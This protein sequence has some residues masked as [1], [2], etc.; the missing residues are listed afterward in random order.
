MKL[1]K[2]D[3]A[4]MSHYTVAEAICKISVSSHLDLELCV[5]VIYFV[6][7]MCYILF[8][9]CYFFLFFFFYTLVYFDD[10]D[11]FFAANCVSA[12]RGKRVRRL[13]GV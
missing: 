4:C 10:I 7:F 12:S 6:I 9:F 3:S 5:C 2:S 8:C 13:G 11:S 1:N